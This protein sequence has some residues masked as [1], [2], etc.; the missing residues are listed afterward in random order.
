MVH[1]SCISHGSVVST[2]GCTGS[3][4][5]DSF[6]YDGI[7]DPL[8][9]SF[10]AD[11]VSDGLDTPSQ[12]PLSMNGK[13]TTLLCLGRTKEKEINRQEPQNHLSEQPYKG[14]NLIYR[15]DNSFHNLQL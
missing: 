3:V 15:S 6:E 2:S 8:P 12:L 13:G 10:K 1:V 14:D 9:N 11:E 5:A 4:A 7:K